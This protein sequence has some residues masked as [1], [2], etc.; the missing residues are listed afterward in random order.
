M[1]SRIREQF[2]TTA[3]I[4][5]VIALVFALAGGAYAAQS[6]SQSKAKQG[7]QGKPGKTGKTGPAGPAG[8]KGD[9]GAQGAA[10][11]QGATGQNGK[12]AVVTKFEAEEGKCEELAGAEVKVEGAASGVEVCD[13]EEGK[14]GS[15]WTAG[16]TLPAGKTETGTWAFNATEASGGN[17]VAS[18]G[19]PIKLAAGLEEGKVHF[20]PSFTA[21]QSVK[22][23]FKAAC[24]KNA[25]SPTAEPGNLC[26]YYAEGE[27]LINATFTEIGLPYLVGFPGAGIAGANL[28]FAFSGEP[29]EAAFGFGTWAVTG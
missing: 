22:D 27:T 1:Y 21:E 10:G 11:A 16:G 6:A 3:L 24:P 5:S 25:V 13:G 29:G 14:E 23:A 12:S 2:S 19:F 26:V 7:K 20:Q 8:P 28:R 15:P 17:I 4:L 18:I 9:P